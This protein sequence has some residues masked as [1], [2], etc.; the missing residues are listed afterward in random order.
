MPGHGV[1]FEPVVHRQCQRRFLKASCM[2]LDVILVAGF[3]A[4]TEAARSS[5]AAS[6]PGLLGRRQREGRL[7]RGRRGTRPLTAPSFG[8][9]T[10]IALSPTL[11]VALPLGCK[12]VAGRPAHLPQI[13]E[14][15]ALRASTI[16]LALLHQGLEL[17]GAPGLVQR[18]AATSCLSCCSGPFMGFSGETLVVA[19]RRRGGDLQV[20]GCWRRGR[21]WMTS[22]F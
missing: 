5:V 15:A 7:H 13:C 4:V 20:G 2:S 9:T 14:E 8:L 1:L 6:R 11:R 21:R 12:Q 17:R 3:G 10:T 16:L 22:I 19:G 18:S